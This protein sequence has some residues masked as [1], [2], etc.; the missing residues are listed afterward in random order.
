[1]KII[2]KIKQF[3]EFFKRKN[4]QKK[5]LQF[6]IGFTIFQVLNKIGIALINP[7]ILL[8]F[9]I[10]K[11]IVLMIIVS[12]ILRFTLIIIYDEKKTDWFFIE[13]IK[14][15]FA[16]WDGKTSPSIENKTKIVKIILYLLIKGGKILGKILSHVALNFYDP[17]LTVIW[18]RKGSFIWNNIPDLLT[19]LYFIISIISC[20]LIS[21][22][23]IKPLLNFLFN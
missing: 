18:A 14:K 9:E 19:W 3:F 1:M 11:A 7:V 10:Y 16:E 21:A 5:V 8:C 20:A 12:F 22:S 15:W 4:I 23:W 17:F 6:G 2:N 13:G